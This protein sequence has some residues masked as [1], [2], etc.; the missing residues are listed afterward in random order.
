MAAAAEEI[1]RELVEQK[2]QGER[3]FRRL[4][5]LRQGT[6]GRLKVQVGIVGLDLGIE[7]LVAGE[8]GIRPVTQ[9]AVD[10]GLR[11]AHAVWPGRLA[12]IM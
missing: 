10:D 3:A 7:R 11:R 1:A 5:P 2:E 12:N 9:P 8:P 4:L 6:A